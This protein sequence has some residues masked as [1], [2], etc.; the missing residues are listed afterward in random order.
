MAVTT[1]Q[2][3]YDG[4]IFVGGEFRAAASGG[5][6][7]VLDKAA[8]QPLGSAGA[9]SPEDVARAIAEAGATQ[10]TWAAEGYDVRAGV[11]RNAAFLLQQR[12]AEFVDQIVRETGAI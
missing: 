4:K 2:R 8:Q 1:E 5:A 3:P 11:L 9:A 7:T 10:R 6:D 12:S